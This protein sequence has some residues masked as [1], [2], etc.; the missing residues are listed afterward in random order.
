MY[1]KGVFASSLINALNQTHFCNI[2]DW[3]DREDASRIQKIPEE[4][5]KYII[6]AITDYSSVIISL[7]VLKKLGVD[8]D[9]IL[10]IQGKNLCVENLPYEIRML[11]E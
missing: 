4:S 3:I 6:I 1:G 7:N 5:Y 8:A 2:V 11:L 9:K 10:Y